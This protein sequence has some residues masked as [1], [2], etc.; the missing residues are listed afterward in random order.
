MKYRNHS[1]SDIIKEGLPVSLT[2]GALACCFSIGV[3]IPLGF[4]TSVH[5]GQWQDYLGSLVALIVICV[6]GLVIGPILVMFFA[7]DLHWFPVALWG[8]PWRAILPTF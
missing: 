5:K 2:L 4:Y 3:G 7:V 1:V 8:S 6:P